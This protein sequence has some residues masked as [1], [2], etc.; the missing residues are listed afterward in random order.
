MR[1]ATAIES[2]LTP[3]QLEHYLRNK[4]SPDIIAT[5]HAVTVADVRALAARWG[6][7]HLSGRVK[8]VV[9][10]SRPK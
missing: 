4:V 3:A 1:P 6:L 5:A 8:A 7:D 10:I 9:T 2:G